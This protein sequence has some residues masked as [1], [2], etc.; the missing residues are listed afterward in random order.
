MLNCLFA[1]ASKTLL[2]FGQNQLNGTPGFW[3]ILH[4]WD[5]KLNAHF[6]LHC[7]VAGGVV[8]KDAKGFIPYTGNY[9]FNQQALS[10]V[11]RAKFMQHMGHDCQNKKI[12]RAAQAYK[13]L[14][15][16]LFTKPWVVSVRDPVRQPDHVLEYRARYTHRVAIAN[17]RIK[18]LK[19]GRVTFTAKDRKKHLTESITISA[20]EFIRKFLLHSLPKGFVRIRH[21][22]FRANR[23][24]RAKL[25]SIRSLLKLPTPAA[26]MQ[27]S[28]EKIMLQL[29]DID[30]TTCPCCNQG[31]MLLLAKIPIYRA[32]APN[33]L[34]HAAC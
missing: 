28:F 31:K 15:N 9:L 16:T 17:S 2:S 26:K 25:N 23:N 27:A 4:S 11:F 21:Y 6:H 33:Y 34:A 8:T 32:R 24:R 22:G 13:Q 14:K 10:R 3:A 7:L 18:S 20:V 1:A 12:R 19:H 30:I 5:Q 29:T